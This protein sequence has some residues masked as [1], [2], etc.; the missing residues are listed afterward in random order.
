MSQDKKT[1]KNFAQQGVD[2]MVMLPKVVED[3]IIEN[4]NKRYNHDLIYT[5]IGSVLISVNPFKFIPITGQ[6]YVERYQG[7]FRHENSPH[8]FALAEETYRAMKN[9]G[10]NQCVIISG[11]SGAGK[12]EASKLIMQYV[13]A[14]SGN[15][16]GVE[17]VKHVILESN[18]L[19][20]AF[21]NAKTLRNNNSSRFGKYFEIVFNNYGD[22]SG[23]RITNYLLEKS[24]VVFQTQGER[25]FHIFYELLNGATDDELQKWQL[26]DPQHFHYL[27]QSGCFEVEGVDDAKDFQDVRKA[28]GIIGLTPAEQD[29]VLTLVAGILHTGNVAFVEEKSGNAAVYDSQVLELA[30]NMLKVDAQTLQSAL[31]FRVIN[32]GTAGSGGRMSTYSVPQNVE[33]ANSARDALTKVIYSRMFDYLVGKVNEALAKGNGQHKAHIGVLDIFG[34][35][36]FKVFYNIIYNGL[37]LILI[38]P[39]SSKMGSSNFVLTL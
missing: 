16:E 21:G 31:L 24:R 12:T 32:T 22:P 10:E 18:P 9:E 7:K 2:D 4:L 17:Y 13:S 25:N 8:I 19:L 6:D 1:A 14:V 38:Q 15:S 23:G 34:F 37:F 26:Y 35:E 27:N 39:I 30:A 36:I 3:Q 11:E 33:Q 29:D 20:E 28:M 5:N